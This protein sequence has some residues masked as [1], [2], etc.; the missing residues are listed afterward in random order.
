MKDHELRE[1]I[2][3]ITTVA[4]IYAH[5]QQLR[6]QISHLIVPAIKVLQ[7]RCETS[8]LILAHGD[9]VIESQRKQVMRQREEMIA[10]LKD[11]NSLLA[12]IQA[13]HKLAELVTDYNILSI[14]NKAI[15][16]AN[17][18][19]FEDGHDCEGF[20]GGCERMGCPGGS[21]CTE[22]PPT[23]IPSSGSNP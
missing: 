4:K 2:N 3:D 18:P 14:C 1:L 19:D 9:K 5:T 8:D 16:N 15:S 10:C 13:I 7:E 22:L 12:D 17:G 11:K 21:E 20:I 23:P 6:E